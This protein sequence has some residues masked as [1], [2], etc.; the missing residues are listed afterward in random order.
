MLN[1]YFMVLVGYSCV[2][3]MAAASLHNS[4]NID[5]LFRPAQHWLLLNVTT[6]LSPRTVLQNCCPVGSTCEAGNFY[7]NIVTF[8]FPLWIP[9]QLEKS[10][11]QFKILFNSARLPAH[12]YYVLSS[13]YQLKCILYTNLCQGTFW[14]WATDNCFVG[15]IIQLACPYT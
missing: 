14:Q 5:L 9:S 4:N 11:V 3:Y 1:A 6:T 12:L 13:P 15:T 7:L 8:S 2:K 10:F